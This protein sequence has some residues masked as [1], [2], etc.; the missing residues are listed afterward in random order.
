M[1]A[2]EKKRLIRE[3]LRALAASHAA[4]VAQIEETMAV[5]SSALELDDPGNDDMPGSETSRRPVADATTFCAVW[6]GKTCFLGNTLLF[7]LFD[8]L[9][10]TP[11]RYVSHVDLLEE[12]WRSK[13]ESSTIRGVAKRLRDRLVDA[14]MADLASAIDGS[15][16]G[17][18]GLKLV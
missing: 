7:W 14:G 4:A 16:T 11:G 15:V 13:R 12:V 10:R 18:Y 2:T 1:L 9:A 6:R 17:Y 5:L 8:R 3:S